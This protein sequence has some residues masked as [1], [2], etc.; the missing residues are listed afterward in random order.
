[1]Y[2]EPNVLI[3]LLT[4]LSVDGKW[5]AAD[6]F[7]GEI[8]NF[9]LGGLFSEEQRSALMQRAMAHFSRKREI[10]DLMMAL[11][12]GNLWRN[13]R[14]VRARY[15]VSAFQTSGAQRGGKSVP[16]EPAQLKHKKS[17]LEEYI[18]SLY[19]YVQKERALV[20]HPTRILPRGD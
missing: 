19:G 9:F 1:M 3:C 5:V 4:G 20:S 17:S 6:C 12:P 18:D 8:W 2:S 7:P 13:S 10:L 11:E 16:V 14:Q 15:L